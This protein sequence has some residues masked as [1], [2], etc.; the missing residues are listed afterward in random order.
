MLARLFLRL[1]DSLGCEG[2][3]SV[4]LGFKDAVC[5][6]LMSALY[7]SCGSWCAIA[8]VL[9]C[10]GIPANVFGRKRLRKSLWGDEYEDLVDLLLYSSCIVLL[11]RRWMT[12]RF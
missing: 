8:W 5:C 10:Y 7:W 2:I 12:P 6:E 11:S 3:S 9:C 4:Y 1:G